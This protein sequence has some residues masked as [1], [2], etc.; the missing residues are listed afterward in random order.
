MTHENL[1][2]LSLAELKSQIQGNIDFARRKGLAID[3]TSSSPASTRVSTTR[4]WPRRS[5]RLGIRWIAADNSRQPA[6][7]G[8]GNA[9]TVPRHRRTSTTTSAASPSS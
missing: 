4:T 2:N 1:D 9:L 3:A 5:T 6:P 8:L 7:F